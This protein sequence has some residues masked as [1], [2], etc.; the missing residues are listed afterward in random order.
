MQ[1]CVSV[2]TLLLISFVVSKL[3]SIFAAD[4]II[5]RMVLT[6]E[7]RTA[8]NYLQLLNTLSK[9]VRL[10]VVSKLSDSI[11]REETLGRT[12]VSRRKARVVN[13]SVSKKI[14]D[15]QLEARFAD[16][17]MPSYPPT[18]PTWAEVI[19]SNSGKTIKPVEKWL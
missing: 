14:S 9:E 18:E 13:R 6:T 7:Y 11:F 10:Y 16:K 15:E 17:P 19:D 3:L 5:N 4:K 2:F 1:L 12:P 8:D